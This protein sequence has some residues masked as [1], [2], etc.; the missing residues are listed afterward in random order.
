MADAWYCAER[1][2]F[3]GATVDDVVGALSSAASAGGWHVEVDQHKEWTTSVH[4]LQ[5]E[6]T[7][8]AKNG[9]EMLRDALSSPELA[10]FTD[11]ILE[12]NFRRRGLRMD[13][14]LIAPGLIAV[15]EF[16]RSRLCAAD[17][18]QVTNYCV[19]LVEFHEETRRLCDD[20]DVVLVPILALTEGKQT[21]IQ[22]AGGAFHGGPWGNVARDPVEC[23]AR[24]LKAAL[25]KALG[26]RR[27]RAAVSCQAWLA[28]RFAPSSTIL[29]A[30]ISLYGQHEVSAISD[31]AA[32]VQRIEECTKHV[33]DH[34]SEAKS[35]KR[36]R[37]I[38][39][40]GTPGSGKTLV[41][42][43]LAFDP[44]FR[45]DA[46]FV[47]GNAPLVDVLSKALEHSYKGLA[48]RP[49]Q[50]LASGY[51]RESIAHVIRNATF[52][53]VKAHRFLGERGKHTTASDGS[54]V[55]FDEAQRTYEKGRQVAGHS[56][57][58]H[59]ADL[60]LA[61]L[62]KSYDPGAVVV[63]L[64]GH[65]QDINVGERGAIAWFEAAERR[66]W[67]CAI[68]DATLNLPEF[69]EHSAWRTHPLRKELR[70]G[71]LSHSMRFYRNKGI[72]EWAHALLENQPDEARRLAKA[73][74]A[75]GHSLWLTRDLAKAKQWARAQRVGEERMG[76]I[77]SGQA[78][79]LMAEG[80]F[81]GQ[82]PPIDHWMLAPTGDVR[83]SNMLETIQNTYQVQGLELD[84]TIVCWDADL[85][86]D[87]EW[88]AF[89]MSG[90]TW[91]R[92]RRPDIA[93]NGYRVLLTRA[94][95]GMALFVPRGDLTG[96]DDTRCR[97]FY[98]GIARY[99][100][101]CGAR[102]LAQ[103]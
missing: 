82:K 15:L 40:S 58:D 50:G 19:N 48:R 9:V 91:Q 78:R 75:E 46:V 27:G 97:E 98:D 77:A 68:A 7:T 44:R 6:L 64:L 54:V 55:I 35:D 24:T 8:T 100:E 84:Y 52:K 86:H 61:S 13:C 39:V 99:L 73:L 85:R 41:G 30:A 10:E 65:N 103:A 87:G 71:H 28:S 57:A 12:Y 37:I 56:L 32:P 16:K 18:D 47:T 83:S 80:L 69:A 102:E 34:I 72:E 70:A 38:F 67:D 90:S 14:V 96:E 45:D 81:V 42:L 20:E 21:P 60:I 101:S 74:D 17:K 88:R 94:R 31:H 33:A 3:L 22:S 23:D 4:L 1:G 93:Q 53:I 29:D 49:G 76:M 11:V 26:M 95:K 79:R 92:D 36:N 89:K 5:A 25:A 59:E 66:D 63:A 2:V 51:P 62:E 43:N